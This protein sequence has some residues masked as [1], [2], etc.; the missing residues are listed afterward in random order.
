MTV[1]LTSPSLN[2]HSSI[3]AYFKMGWN[4]SAWLCQY[5]TI[6]VVNSVHCVYKFACFYRA[7]LVEIIHSNWNYKECSYR[8]GGICFVYHIYK[9]L[10][11]M[12]IFTP[13]RHELFEKLKVIHNVNKEWKASMSVFWK[14]KFNRICDERMHFLL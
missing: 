6:S 8:P 12:E 5:W 7:I 9:A 1:I 10:R 3:T 11:H 14:G 4:S 13:T 2:S